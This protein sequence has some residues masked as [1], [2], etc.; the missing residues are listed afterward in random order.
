MEVTRWRRRQC[1]NRN[2]ADVIYGITIWRVLEEERALRSKDAIFR[3]HAECMERDVITGAVRV[4]SF[5]GQEKSVAIPYA[6]LS[7]ASAPSVILAAFAAI[8][9]RVKIIAAQRERK[10][11]ARNVLACF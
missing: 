9:A 6:S 5:V 8:A 2:A 4:G 7:A 10:S 3:L 11:G 1:A